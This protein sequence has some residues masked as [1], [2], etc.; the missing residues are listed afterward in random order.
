MSKAKVLKYDVF[1]APESPFNGPPARVA[2]SDPP[3]WDPKTATLIFGERDAV[4]VDALLTIREATAL[5][6]W[7]ELHERRLTTIYITHGHGDH[8]LGLPVLLDRFPGARV[9]ATKGTVEL[10]RKNTTPDV[11]DNGFRARFPGQISDTTVLA[12]ALDSMQFDIEG[13]PLVVVEAGHTD[14]FNTTSLH[15]P[16]IGLVVSG[17]VAYNRCHMFASAT[18][19]ESRTEWVAAL[20][21]LAALRPTAVVTGHKDPTQAMCRPRLTSHENTSNSTENNGKRV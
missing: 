9:V 10:M 3:A 13:W 20:D 14:T 19:P 4:L 7:I 8:F 1:V 12:E 16:D 17:D 6:K 18:T 5:A 11:L 21:L 2:N 15:V